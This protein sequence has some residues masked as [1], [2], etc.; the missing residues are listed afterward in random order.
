MA[1][2]FRNDPNYLLKVC[3]GLESLRQGNK[4][5]IRESQIEAFNGTN[6]IV[7]D[8][9]KYLFTVGTL[10]IPIL[11]S[12]VTIGDIRQRL[13]QRDSV[14]I[15]LSLVFLFTSLVSGFVHMISELKYFRKWLKNQ[16][17]K[18]R[19]WATTSFWPSD[20]SPEKIKDYIND[21]DSLKQKS[22]D[23]A[24]EMEKESTMIFLI[25]QGVFWFIGI[26]PI[27]IIIFRYL[28]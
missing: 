6:K 3:E 21:Y 5:D 4:N 27:V 7:S 2:S 19:L 11:F 12:L 8:L 26:I 25:F 23:I 16:D 9:N 17:K 28:P 24:L 1:N 22:D 10:L 14:L 15:M 20:P 18:L 13:D